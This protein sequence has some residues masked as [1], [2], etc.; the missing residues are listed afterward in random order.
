MKI[1]ELAAENFK[2]LRVVE[3]TPDGRPVIQ[4]TGGNGQGKTTVL[5]SIWFGLKGQ[6]ALPERKGD[7]VRRGAERMK[8][9]VKL[10]NGQMQPFTI[11]RTLGTEGNPPTLAIVPAVH[12]DSGKTPQ[13]YLDDLFGA[14]TFDPLAF[15]QMDATDQVEE[16]KKTAKMSLDFEKLAEQDE[17]DY[18]ERHATGREIDLLKGQLAGMT[19]IE[20]LPKEKIDTAPIV[21]KLNQA[22]ELNKAAQETFAAKQKM[23]AEAAQLGVD[24]TRKAHEIETQ[25]QTIRM[26][27]EQLAAAKARHK[28]LLADLAE[29]GRKHTAAEKAYQAA[30]AGEPIDVGALTT[31]LQS[32]ERTNRAIDQRAEFDR[33]KAHRDELQKKYDKLTRAIEERDEKRKVATANAKMPVEGLTFDQS[34]GKFRVKFLGTPFKELGE[35]EQIRISTQIGMA[36]NPK[37]RVLCIRH[38]EALDEKGIKVIAE[39]AKANDFQVWMARVDTS[40]KVGIVMED[41]SVAARNED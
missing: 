8:V 28:Q 5:D 6:K 38:G 16:L 41:G 3:I 25:E 27:E 24:K 19:V 22:A 9:S 10:G 40:G 21:K 1:L 13:A 31:E 35:G 11:T 12:K 7:A 29:L 26:I 17:A 14:L 33:I 32:A 4:I 20:G 36:A 30:P 23:G 39:L 34:D 2:K 37:L 15:A 18:K